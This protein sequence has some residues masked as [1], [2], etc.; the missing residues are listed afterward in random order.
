MV[1]CAFAAD[2]L[3]SSPK[4]TATH[5]ALSALFALEEPQPSVERL[6]Q[7]VRYIVGDGVELPMALD[8]AI[9]EM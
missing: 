5:L 9:G 4:E 6:L 7:E 2:A 1:T 8:D 3:A